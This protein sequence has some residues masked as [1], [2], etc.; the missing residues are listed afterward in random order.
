MWYS[1]SMIYRQWAL[2]SA[3][4]TQQGPI[5]SRPSDFPQWYLSL[6][7]WVNSG[8]QC[9]DRFNDTQGDPPTVLQNVMAIKNRLNITGQ[10]LG[11][12]WYEWQ[13]GFDDLCVKDHGAHRFK[14]DTEYP[15]YFPARRGAGFRDIVEQLRAASVYTFPYINGRIFDNNSKS[16]TTE[17]G[18]AS[19]VKQPSAAPTLRKGGSG[20]A[21]TVTADSKASLG[22]YRINGHLWWDGGKGQLRLS[23][24]LD[25]G[26]LTGGRPRGLCCHASGRR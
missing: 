1:A 6:N 26:R 23:D 15:D 2:A 14:F 12:H 21:A 17:D 22:G 8:W 4:W 10:G 19:V 11:L 24:R 16:F 3:Q 25:Q 20:R 13:C 18:L 7:V 9:Y 5:A